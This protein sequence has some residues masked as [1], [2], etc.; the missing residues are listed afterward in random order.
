[1]QLLGKSPVGQNNF[2][3]NDVQSDS[4]CVPIFI[5]S[6]LNSTRVYNKC[7]QKHST[8][9]RGCQKSPDGLLFQVDF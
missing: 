6:I 4:P 5:L 1:M 7:V 9:K 8:L 2:V 3:C